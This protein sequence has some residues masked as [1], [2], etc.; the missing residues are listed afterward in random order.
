MDRCC[1]ACRKYV[2]PK[3]FLQCSLCK[4]KYHHMCLNIKSAQFATLSKEY[5]SS[6][7]CPSCNNVTRRT[8]SNCN[9]PVRSTQVPTEPM[10]VS[11]DILNLDASID[12]KCM[13]SEPV[14]DT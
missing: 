14:R 8:G 2:E 10:N 9:T 3:T 4:L 13:T 12:S 11:G 6:W 5:L 7:I 1:D